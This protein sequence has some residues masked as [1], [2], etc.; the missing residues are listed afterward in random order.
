MVRCV[1]RRAAAVLWLVAGV[2]AGL[3]GTTGVAR[4]RVHTVAVAERPIVALAAGGGRVAYRTRERDVVGHVCDSVRVVGAGGATWTPLNCNLSRDPYGGPPTVWENPTIGL[5]LAGRVLAY[6]WVGIGPLNATHDEAETRLWRYGAD[7][8]RRLDTEFYEVTCHGSAVGPMAV[9]G[10]GVAFTRTVAVEVDPG[11]ECDLGSGG[12]DGTASMTSATLEF[13]PAGMTAP[14]VVSGAPGAAR[15][16]LN[17]T[18]A[19][20]VPL[21][22]PQQM[23]KRVLPPRSG[24]AAVQSWDLAAGTRRCTATLRATPSSVATN[25]HQIAALVPGG[26]HSHLV[27]LS[28]RTCGVL[29]DRTLD[30]ARPG[31]ALA[32]RFVVWAAGRAVLAMNLRTGRVQRLHTGSLPAHDVTVSGGQVFWW[33]RGTKRSRILRAALP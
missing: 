8:R 6:D 10:G 4:A 11:L 12:G 15:I 26:V 9:S 16:A 20:I 31:V 27:R 13:V 17:G 1:S 5:G 23:R 33:I 21:E 28:A 29:G 7:R 24:T 19:A 18:D 25:G 14:A 30:H 32:N 3:A 2:V 22:L